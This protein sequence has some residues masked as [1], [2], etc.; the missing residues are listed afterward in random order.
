MANGDLMNVHLAEMKFVSDQMHTRMAM[1]SRLVSISAALFSAQFFVFFSDLRPLESSSPSMTLL[2][3]SP[4]IML[5]LGLLIAREH[6]LMISHDD[7]FL[8]TLRPAILS[9]LTTTSA[10][11]ETTL[12]F[13]AST[14]KC[15]TPFLRG[16][17]GAFFT[18]FLFLAFSCF[19]S[20]GCCILEDSD[21]RQPRCLA[22]Q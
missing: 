2:V 5:G 19:R 4:L 21:G 7:Y 13:L 12:G 6:S 10:E 1:V 8:N 11:T 15:K 14:S 22:F 3:L 20:L 17:S 16:A 9:E 18:S